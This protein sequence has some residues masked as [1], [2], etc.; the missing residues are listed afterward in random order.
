[1]RNVPSN[2]CLL[3]VNKSIWRCDFIHSWEHIRARSL[4]TW[5]R[6]RR[7]CLFKR[8]RPMWMDRCR[9]RMIT[10]RRLIGLSLSHKLHSSTSRYRVWGLIRRSRSLEETTS[11]AEWRN[12]V[13]LIFW[14]LLFD[15]CTTYLSFCLVISI[16]WGLSDLNRTFRWKIHSIL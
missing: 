16:D 5:S 3:F 9:I 2:S 13:V 14:W 10:C 4:S 7:A 6:S 1:M 15:W 8:S 11:I 12:R